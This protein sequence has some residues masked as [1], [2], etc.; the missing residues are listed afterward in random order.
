MIRLE[1]KNSEINGIQTEE[2]SQY[3]QISI[4]FACYI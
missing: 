2:S 3:L 1:K 4:D